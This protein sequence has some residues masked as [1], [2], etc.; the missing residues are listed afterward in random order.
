MKNKYIV[1]LLLMFGVASVSASDLAPILL[2]DSDSQET[3]I[4]D[5]E[6]VLE[7][8]VSSPSQKEGVK[9]WSYSSEDKYVSVIFMK[10]AHQAKY[11][12]V[13][14]ASTDF[15]I[16][17]T[18]IIKDATFQEAVN[19]VLKS[20]RDSEH[21]LKSEWYKNNVVVITEY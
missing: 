2:T 10:W 19:D 11:Q 8:V 4:D 17:S 1:A 18:G 12:L 7:P 3:I 20:L 9:N 14:Q 13:W 5:D 15:E 16:Q 6:D 21:P